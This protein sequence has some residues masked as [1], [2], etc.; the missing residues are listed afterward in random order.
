[1]TSPFCRAA[2]ANAQPSQ[3][4][5]SSPSS[6][7]K[8]GKPPA[9]QDY[10]RHKGS[11]RAQAWP[12]LHS[13]AGPLG[14]GAGK[15]AVH[16]QVAELQ[17]K[18]QL[19]EDDR[20]VFYESSQWNI[21]RNQD[22]IKHLR[23]ETKALQLQLTDLLQGDEK[24]V[25]TIIQE[26]KSEK[27]YL[28]SRTVQALE[29]LDHQLS[30]KVKQLNAVR[31]QVVLRQRRLE[32]LQ[33]QHSLRQL[34]VAEMQ[35]SSTEMAKTMRNLENRLEKARMKMDEA[36]HITSVYLQLKAYLQEESLTLES[37][38][39]SMEAEVVSTRREVQELRAVNH[40][41][42]NARDVAKGQ[43][44]SLEEGVLRE[45]KKR[46]RHVTECKKR[47][48]EK[49]LQTERMERKTQRDPVVLQS[50]ETIQD[51]HRAKQKD[52]RQR[53]DMYQ[54]EVT[55]GKV[56]D[57][58][59]AAETHSVVR[60]FLAQGDTFVQLEALKKENEQAL[61]QLKDEKRRL[62][63]E[64]EGLKYSG[65][66]ATVSQKNL[67]TEMQATLASQEKRHAEA[68]DQLE[69]TLRTMRVAKDS[70]EHLASKLN[71]VTV[72]NSRFSGTVLD[73]NADNYLPTL[74]G[75]VEEK[76]LKLQGQLQSHDVPETLRRI[77][78]REFLATLEGKLPPYNT[79]IPLPV[80]SPKDKFFD[81]EESGEEDDVVSRAT[82]KIRSQKLIEARSKK[83]GH[84]RRS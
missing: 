6:K 11:A 57:A 21:R 1:M 25:Q 30:G 76:L 49:K 10:A 4:Q 71:H 70:L 13:K 34:E 27:P 46:E 58:T 5:A 22:T 18:I 32:E 60:R 82:F 65:E 56:K 15:P 48:E 9:K 3:E 84:S 8:G 63:R 51:H 52:L 75:V 64:L 47:A 43:L 29:H 36:G 26:W 79:R 24:V 59:G 50:E 42:L 66:A 28:K 53:W 77:A 16:T 54:L 12:A 2:S 81:E 38:L 68:R 61:A 78:E 74:L 31:H 83:R 33:L 45:R 80:A 17:R 73:R 44:Q 39:D 37:Q 19:L 35:D 41:A 40:E 69:R 20:K 67:Q 72:E 55:F 7:A 62:Q 14:R 23:E